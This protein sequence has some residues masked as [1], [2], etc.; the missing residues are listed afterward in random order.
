MIRLSFP[1]LGILVSTGLV[2]AEPVVFLSPRGGETLQG[3][4]VVEIRV[5]GVPAD[6][7]EFEIL[8]SAAPGRAVSFRLTG[9]LEP[10][11]RSI[12]WTVP[13]LVLPQAVLR[14]RMGRD[15]LEFESAPSAAFAIE[16]SSSHT[17]AQL[18]YRHGELWVSDGSGEASTSYALP[19]MAMTPSREVIRRRR[20]RSKILVPDPLPC[21]PVWTECAHAALSGSEPSS[22][23]SQAGA[24]SRAPRDIPRRI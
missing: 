1:F 17:T 6:V 11:T 9:T 23:F 7:E 18:A 5:D 21:D 3:G 8:L 2:V 4:Q 14:L 12:S 19:G 16:P 24:R 10:T 13:D 20:G 22:D 15:E